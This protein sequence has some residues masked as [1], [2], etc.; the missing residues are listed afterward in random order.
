MADR[1]LKNYLGRLKS[2][3]AAPPTGEWTDCQLLERFA[4]QRDEAAFASLVRRHGS[5]VLGVGRRIL[6]QDQDAEDVFQA[7]FI[8]LARKAASAGWQKSIAGWL[9]KVAYRLALRTRTQMARQRALQRAVGIASGTKSSTIEESQEMLAVLDE[10]LHHLADKYREPLLLCYLEAKTR[11]QAARQ[12]GWSLRTLERR[13]QQGLNLLRAR[14]SKRGVELP[15]ALLA[16][17]LSQ[18]AASA[19]ISAAKVAVTVEAASAFGSGAATA[20]G[21]V[22]AR[23]TALAEEGMKDMALAT[24][25]T[26]VVV[27]L[28]ATVMLA[29]VGALGNYMRATKPA[30]PEP[31]AQE[32]TANAAPVEVWPEGAIVQ[33]RVVDPRGVAVPNAEVLLLG[34][35]H[36]IVDAERRN[37]FVPQRE[38]KLPDPPSTR[39]DPK[40]E[41]RIERKKGTA[42]RLAVIA[43]DPLFWVVKRKSLPQGENVEI[44]LPMACSLAIKCDL[45][46]KV[47]KQ[48]VNIE[49]RTL[50]GVGWSDDVLRFHFGSFSVANPGEKVFEHLPPGQYVVQRFQE[51]PTGKTVLLTG[52]DRQLAKV[53]P[54]QSVTIRIDR[55]VGRPLEGQVR[56]LE[57]IQLSYAQVRIGYAGPEE[58]FDAKGRRT[59]ILTGFDTI[60]IKADGRFTTDPIPPGEYYL[61]LFA[62]RASTPE[63]SSQGSDFNGQLRFTVPERGEMPKIEIV[64]KPVPEKQRLQIPNTDYRVQVVDDTG[65]PVPTLQAMVYTTNTVGGSEWKA[66]GSGIAD[67]GGPD[68]FRDDGV[69]GV[70]VRADGFASSFARLEG[71]NHNKLQKGEIS[72]TMQRGQKVELRFRLPEGLTWPK[73]VLPEAYFTDLEADVRIMRQPSNRRPGMRQNL[74]FNMLNVRE[75]GAGRF[76]I[77]LAPDTPPFHLAIHTPGFL[78]YFEAGPFTLA[79]VKQGVLEID[80]PRPAGLDIQFS[81]GSDNADAIPFKGVW[82]QV[83]R[84]IQ[85]ESYLGVATDEA[86]SV[87]HQ[88]KLTDLPPGTYLVNVFTQ[89]KPE[90]KPLVGTEINP[91]SYHDQKK[92]V[93]EAG[94]SEQV[95]FRYAPFDLQAFRGQRTAVLRI[96]RPDGT[97]AANR[98]LKVEYQ[99]GHY[100]RQLVFAGRIPESG[101]VTLKDLTDRVAS[102]CPNRLAYAVTVDGKSVGSFGFTNDRPTQEF[103]F[104]LAPRAGDPAPD[105]V[106]RNVATGKS[107]ELRSLRGKIVCLEF[108]AT[109]CGPCQ[110]AMAKLTELSAERSSTWKDRVVLV[111]LSIDDTADRVQRHVSRRGW[112][113]L[114]HFWTG[115]KTQVGWD[116]PAARAFGV[117]GV[118]ETILIGADG[119]ILWRGHPLQKFS[120]QDLKSR[121]ESELKK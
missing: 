107:I 40:G 68:L 99:G 38:K 12:L 4:H 74:D 119:R 55:K 49:S 14:L 83:L 100:G 114:D 75:M 51:T 26:R 2:M 101:E 22:S 81:P 66:G 28:A 54:N 41:F 61:D 120:G 13:L 91:G 21:K 116:A 110:P 65:K 47:P 45:P 115:D 85:G 82:F 98:E 121:I 117:F 60:P 76:E 30:E 10:E 113:R 93:L 35:E 86:P 50:E 96:R 7:T 73:G 43:D 44:K 69:S 95:D 17:G 59:R 104:H 84:Q 57:N 32:K 64:A 108:W 36:V 79:D 23:V 46:G 37:W 24:M 52:S 53:G 15:V 42:N 87:K 5:L 62:T 89:P 16:A 39:T 72:I 105:V 77:R 3:L 19:G 58:Q 88:L 94:K 11:D 31:A 34:E 1:S 111:P 118:P 6:Q 67:L 92:L 97:P 63:K 25:K 102:F 27:L 48:P 71:D 109:W 78:Q 33:G 18:Q 29:G 106:L 70:V 9:Y 20:G 8:M 56:G 80:V 90:S 112:D 103:D